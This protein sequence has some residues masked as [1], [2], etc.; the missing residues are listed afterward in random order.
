MDPS[1]VKLVLTGLSAAGYWYSLT[2]P[3]YP[4]DKDQ[5]HVDGFF[6]FIAHNLSRISKTAIVTAMIF[7]M[8][9]I[10]AIQYP[11]SP[12]S[13]LVLSRICNV[14]NPRSIS[15]VSPLFLFGASLVI[16]NALVRAWCYHSLGT[17]FTFQITI[18]KDHRLIKTGPY[19]YVRHPGYTA[20]ILVI[21]GA[22]IMLAESGGWIQQCNLNHTFV[23]MLL[24]AFHFLSIFSTTSMLRRGK[25]EDEGL[26]KV[27][28]DEWAVYSR[29]VPCRFIPGVL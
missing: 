4:S 14:S 21:L 28:G 2:P 10:A 13:S 20:L 26:K 9:T 24:Y 25:I 15:A 23:G 16:S 5:L 19:A 6:G 17:L 1:H 12:Q 18:R 29:K 7:E 27:F 22:N 3:D 11:T 8:L